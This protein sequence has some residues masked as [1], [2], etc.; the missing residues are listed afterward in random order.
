M[1]VHFPFND[2][3]LDIEKRL[4]DLME[5]LTLQEKISLIP[6]QTK[7]I[8]RLGIKAYDVGAEGAHGFVDRNGKSTTFPQTIG[9]SSTWNREL[10][11]KIGQVIGTE[12]RAYFNRGNAKSGLSLWFP[13]IDM[14]KDPRWGRTEEGY[15]EDPF[16]AGELAGEI[17]KGC[18][19]DD[20]EYIRASCAPKH[21]FA[22]NNEKNRCSCSCSVDPR[23]MNEYYLES[24]RR[25]FEKAK[26]FSLMTAYNEVNGVPLIQHTAVNDYVKEKWGLKGRGHIVSDGG[27]V[28]QTVDFHHYFTRHSQTIA[29]AFKAGSDCMTDLPE[30]VIPAVNEA[31]E[32][33]LITEKEL[34]EHLRN[35]LRVKMRLGLFNK[36]GTC[37]Y[38]CIT[39]KDMMKESSKALAR[40][41]SRESFVLLKN[42]NILPLKDNELKKIAVIG[43]LADSVY[44][45][46]YTG[47]PDYRV[48]P[49]QAL[50]EL[51]GS[52]IVYSSAKDTVSFKT[53]DGK[54]LVLNSNAELVIG[55]KNQK[56]AVFVRDDWGWGANT[57]Y[58][59]ELNM[60]LQT[61]DALPSDHQPSALEME[62][63]KKH[64]SPGKLVCNAKDTLSWFVSSLFNIIPD[65][66]NTDKDNVLLRSWNSKAVKVMDSS[67]TAQDSDFADSFVIT[68][69]SDGIQNAV[70]TA[71]NADV[72]LL[73]CGS[74]PM[75]NG[76]EEIDRVS[77]ELPPYQR[78]LIKRIMQVNKNTALI[79]IS[80]Y[81]YTLKDIAKTVPCIAWTAHGMQEEGNGIADIIS[82]KESPCG[83][84]S[85]TWYKDVKDLPDMMEYDIIKSCNTYRYFNGTP[86]Y[87]FGHGLTYTQFKYTNMRFSDNCITDKPFTVKVDV[88]NCGNTDSFEVVQLYITQENTKITLPKKQLKGFEKVFIEKGKTKTVTFTI[89]KKDFEIYDVVQQKMC[90]QNGKAVILLGSSSSDIRLYGKVDLKGTD[91][92]LR[93]PFIKTDAWN[94]SD[95]N[96]CYLHEKRGSK[97]PAVFSKES[98]GYI[99][100]KDFDFNKDCNSFTA[101]VLCKGYGTLEIRKDSL[102]GKVILFT[103]L[104]NTGDNC[105]VP[106]NKVRAVWATIRKSIEKIDGVCDL[107]IILNGNIGIHN[108]T[109]N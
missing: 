59:K 23:N 74:N 34:D 97:I 103:E 106:G 107:Y 11:Y 6:T 16:L 51:Y 63:F 36:K 101:Q 65:F 76:K 22:N 46:W 72:V 98:T 77:L 64:G 71:E 94:Y 89:S 56:P 5:R 53:Q 40:K 26:P 32:Q 69:E 3:S 43:P 27:D 14:E 102:D 18:Q 10:L 8:E 83:K 92:P 25:V 87:C 58:S 79:L 2:E 84:L 13:T 86:L 75:I 42:N 19:G 96:N 44:T 37:P 28:S 20:K 62:N 104:P 35:I 55:T 17:I 12:A 73:F 21:F 91:I 54:P 4:D 9:L 60:Y 29:A 95:Y 67:I 100:Y 85:L 47:M 33:K 61:V 45:D 39:E 52:K 7:D 1:E 38:D 57:L 48:T 108:F 68:K 80:G 50:K 90:A 70:E 105:A 31:L 82:G 41:A 15:G 93:N 81:P 66:N 99:V 109:F 88:T 30:I 24:F 49:L 78:E